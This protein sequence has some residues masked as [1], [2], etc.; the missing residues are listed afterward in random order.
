MVYLQHY[1]PMVPAMPID[2]ETHIAEL[3]SLH[4]GPLGK[5]SALSPLTEAMGIRKIFFGASGWTFAGKPATIEG[6]NLDE[7]E[8][9][10]CETFI[11]ALRW[12]RE[13]PDNMYHFINL[14][15]ITEGLLKNKRWRHC[16]RDSQASYDLAAHL[17]QMS[18]SGRITVTMQVHHELDP[19]LCDVF[20]E[21]LALEEPYPKLPKSETV[22]RALFGDAWV[23]SMASMDSGLEWRIAEGI[24]LYRPP[25][26]PGLVDFSQDTGDYHLPHLD[27]LS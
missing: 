21:W 6:V 9:L 17:L 14:V 7:H 12:Q 19:L 11:R 23:D 25:F 18:S 13:H 15:A 10:I 3:A 2:Y 16:L 20:N 24:A 1:I 26:L 22:L 27:C 4:F 8:T 5:D